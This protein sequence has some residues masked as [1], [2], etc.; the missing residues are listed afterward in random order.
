MA[1][2]QTNF[3]SGN[4]TN[5]EGVIIFKREIHATNNSLIVNVVAEKEKDH[6]FVHHFI[7]VLPTEWYSRIFFEFSEKLV[8]GAF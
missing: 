5:L 2:D 7:T 6:V 4:E 8:L 1:N 3:L